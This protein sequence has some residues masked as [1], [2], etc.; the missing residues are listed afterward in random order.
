VGI[1]QRWDENAH[2]WIA[3]ARPVGHD[4]FFWELNLPAF[5]PLLPRPSGRCLDLGCG[6]G[7]VGRALIDRGFDV[8]SV[9]GSPTLAGATATAAAASAGRQR[10]AGADAAALPFCE[11][12]FD[13][14]VAFMTFHDVDDMEGAVREAARVLRPGGVLG[15]AIVHPFFSGGAVPMSDRTSTHRR[16][17][18]YFTPRTYAETVEH[19]GLAVTLHS[20]HR[21]LDAHVAA[22]TEAG[23]V[24]DTIREPRPS[25]AYLAAHPD[26]APLEQIPLYLHYRARKPG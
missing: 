15:A 26:A 13:L 12:T 19:A 10:V 18:S 16:R 4:H 24:L 22:V 5:L 9:D 3:W 14:V 11:G 20:V 1:R 17:E 25:A 8:V 6:E 23:L 21:P 2:D 7:R